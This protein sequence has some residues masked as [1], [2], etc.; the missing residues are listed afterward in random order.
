MSASGG[1][2][3]GDDDKGFAEVKK[4]G[5]VYMTSMGPLREGCESCRAERMSPAPSSF[6]SSDFTLNFNTEYESDRVMNAFLRKCFLPHPD[7]D[8][9][10]SPP[11]RG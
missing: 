10:F 2:G 3:R 8:T 9:A 4:K 6:Y 11:Q 5:Y 7:P 1:G